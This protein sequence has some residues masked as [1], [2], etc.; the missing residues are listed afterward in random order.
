[1]EKFFIP[2]FLQA[3]SLKALRL[4]MLKKNVE[5]KTTFVYF[6]IQFVEGF[7]YAFYNDD[8]DLNDPIF[9]GL[10]GVEKKES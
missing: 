2:N 1:L 8:L 10:N 9:E 4:L 5:R 7:W 6:N 3:E